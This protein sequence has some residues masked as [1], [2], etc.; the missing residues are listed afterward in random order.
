MGHVAAA[1]AFPKGMKTAR[2]PTTSTNKNGAAG[3]APAQPGVN[4][5]AT[6]GIFW[7]NGIRLILLV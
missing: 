6:A 5:H 1:S 3:Q 4:R 7:L 2:L